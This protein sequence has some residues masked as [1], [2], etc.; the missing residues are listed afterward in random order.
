[1]RSLARW[2]RCAIHTAER[3]RFN[4]IRS[5]NVGGPRCSRSSPANWAVQKRQECS[6]NSSASNGSANDQ[7][8]VVRLMSWFT[9]ILRVAVDRGIL[10][11]ESDEMAVGS[12]PEE[13]VLQ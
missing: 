9:Q 1:V 5:Q 2:S 12:I 10:L 13:R 3:K 8:F 4:H 11:E 6:D 7:N